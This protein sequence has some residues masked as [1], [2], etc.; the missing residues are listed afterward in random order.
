MPDAF[1]RTELIIGGSAISRL[2]AARV[3]IFGLGGVGSYAAEALSRSGIGGLTIVDDDAI[4]LTN[5]NRQII[6]LHSTVG[7]LKTDVMSERLRDINPLISLDVRAC[8]FDASTSSLFDF[9]SFDYVIDAVDT[10]TAK[11]LLVELCAA[12][13]TPIISCMGMGNK[14]DPTRI[15]V[16]DISRT[17]VCPLA[18]VMRRE[19]KKRGIDHLK[20]VYSKE[21]PLTPVDTDVTSCKH[22]CVCPPQTKRTCAIRRQVPGS[23][24]WVPPAAGLII[25]GEVVKDITNITTERNA[26]E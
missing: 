7:R 3:A 6:A 19:L 23:A 4:C 25:A 8:F 17:S 15:E 24:A 9:R 26:P 5:I 13:N 11:L 14:L 18:R 16:A 1:S 10:V 22:H 20:T 12:A 21:P 2:H